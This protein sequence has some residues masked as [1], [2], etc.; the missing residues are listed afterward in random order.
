MREIEWRHKTVS[1][2]GGD[3]T[4]DNEREERYLSREP[5][6]M[7]HTVLP[8]DRGA[9]FPLV[10]TLGAIEPAHDAIATNWKDGIAQTCELAEIA[11][12]D[13]RGTATPCKISDQS[14]DLGL[15]SHIDSLRR[16]L[17]QQHGNLSG[18]PFGQDHLLRIAAGESVY[19]ELRRTRTNIDEVHKCHYHTI[20]R[21]AVQ[22]ADAREDIEIRK[23]DI[24]ADGLIHH[25][26]PRAFARHHSNPR[27][28]RIS[29][30]LEGSSTAPRLYLDRFF[31]P[32]DAAQ[33]S[34]RTA[35]EEPRQSNNLA[36]PQLE[37]RDAVGP[38]RHNRFA[39]DSGNRL[40]VL[41]RPSRHRA[42]QVCHGEG[43]P[44]TDRRDP[45]IAQHR[46]SIGHCDDLEKLMRNK[47]DGGALL[48]H[49]LQHRK[50]P[51]H[52]PLLQWGGWLI[53]DEDPGFTTQA[54]GN[55]HEWTLGKPERRNGSANVG[56]KVEL[57][58]HR[59]G[60]LAHARAVEQCNRA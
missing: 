16:L 39:P 31:D 21:L 43:T 17:Q 50:Q 35:A 26:S 38:C 28:D 7:R 8:A 9:Q 11:G 10:Q 30:V 40:Y 56:M 55:C 60:L 41:H 34:I 58:Q 52:L 3:C 22:P 32:K 57:F 53:K 20:T 19:F 59:A 25:Q 1:Q 14:V 51:L 6:S 45:P 15:G 27:C 54:L 18:Q 49:A 13:Q 23:Q 29:G 12:I 37:P 36:R 24:V 33:H 5:R 44:A 4:Q 2:Q 47:D 46:A 42:D 48:L